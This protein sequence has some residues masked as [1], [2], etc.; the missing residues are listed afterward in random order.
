M[1]VPLQFRSMGLRRFVHFRC[2][3][4]IFFGHRCRIAT[5]S[6]GSS[7]G[8]PVSLRRLPKRIGKS[9]THRPVCEN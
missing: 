8:D 7:N 9:R 2:C 3:D 4:D 5:I 6:T 1:T